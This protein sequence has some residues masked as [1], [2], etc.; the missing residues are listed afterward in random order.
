M[1]DA[2]YDC[3]V[4][5]GGPAG[6]TAAIYLARFHLSVLVVDA[7]HSRAGMIPKTRNHAGF[8]EGITGP[9]LLRRM[10]QQARIFGAR[11]LEA[12]VE[13]LERDGDGFCARGSFGAM[14]ARAVLLATGVVNN[15]P[16]LTRWIR[17]FGFPPGQLT[18]PNSRTWTE[19]E[20]EAYLA[21]R[22]TATKTRPGHPQ[23]STSRQTA[24]I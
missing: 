7:G 2:A 21:S 5:G 9:N 17:D 16:I 3:L 24:H 23:K 11:I 6:L 4:I 10:N 1:S 22:P 19:E 15:R 12:S 13:T 8:P 18:G 20:I 14:Q